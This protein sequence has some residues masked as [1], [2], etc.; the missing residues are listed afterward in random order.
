MKKILGVLIAGTF[1][2][3]ACDTERD[4]PNTGNYGETDTE[5]NENGEVSTGVAETDEVETIEADQDGDSELDDETMA[6]L[7]QDL[8]E[9]NWD[10]VH[11]TRRQFDTLLYELQDDLTADAEV[12][13]ETEIYIESVDFTDDII[14]ITIINEDESEFSDFTT[15][16]FAVFID[17]FY[18]QLYLNSDYSDGTTHPHII[19]QESDGDIITDQEDFIEFEE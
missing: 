12:D 14:T 5:E 1:L 7:D 4:T 3:G 17:S 15:G 16:F 19:I 9:I 13:E 18:R 11:L 10:E 8:E 6:E 2:L